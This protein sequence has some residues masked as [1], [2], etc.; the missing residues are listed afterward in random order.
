MPSLL[1]P[2]PLPNLVTALLLGMALFAAQAGALK[3]I[4]WLWHR[5]DDDKREKISAVLIFAFGPKFAPVDTLA[6]LLFVNLLAGSVLYAVGLKLPSIGILVL[7]G[8]ALPIFLYHRAAGQRARELELAL[9]LALQQ[10]ANEMAA[11]ATLETALKKVA[12]SAP[13]PADIEIA[14]L[15]R[16]VEIMGIDEAFA[17]MARRLNSR[18]F[19]LTTSVVRVGTSSGG[20]LIEALKSLSRTLIEIERL[21]KKVRTASENGRRN[22]YLMSFVG[23]LVAI[24][25]AFIVDHETSVLDDGLGQLLVGVAV[26]GFVAAHVIGHFLTKAKV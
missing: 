3:A 14:R 20:R 10:V 23:P 15:Q 25:S 9:P 19:T 16:R 13:A 26:L 18:S 22:L 4:G 1:D 21:N 2:G 24:A 6:L 7:L 11:G 17:E 5:L 8:I 12:S